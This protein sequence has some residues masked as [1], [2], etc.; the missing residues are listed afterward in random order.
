M[1]AIDSKINNQVMHRV[2]IIHKEDDK[3]KVKL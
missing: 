1:K 2:S 3:N